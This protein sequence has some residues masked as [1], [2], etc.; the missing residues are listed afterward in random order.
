MSR[1]KLEKNYKAIKELDL[2]ISELSLKYSISFR[3][4]HCSCIWIF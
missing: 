3:S 2:N 1:G 4:M